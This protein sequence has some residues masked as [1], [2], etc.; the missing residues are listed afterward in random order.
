MAR[1]SDFFDPELIHLN[2][3][4]TSR[5]DVI[6]EL[7]SMLISMLELDPRDV[8]ILSN[9]LLRRQ[10]KYGSTGIGRG[11]AFVYGRSLLV[12]ELHVGF[13]RQLTGIDFKAIDNQPVHHFF[14]MVAPPLIQKSDRTHVEYLSIMG[15]LIEI[16][17]KP[18][19]P[20]LLAKVETPEGFLQLMD[21]QS[22]HSESWVQFS[23]R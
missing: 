4:S 18:D 19:M 17:R 14:F 22:H 6:T 10:V 5:D 16:A 23:N 1:L 15:I 9:T 8:T 21:A 7:A 11:I 20:E 13:G 2:L 12:T 3:K